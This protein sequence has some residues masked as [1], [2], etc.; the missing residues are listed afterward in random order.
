MAGAQRPRAAL[1][2]RMIFKGPVL[3]IFAKQPVAGR[4]KTRLC[5]PL[6]PE[7]ACDLYRV[8]LQE[9]MDRVA[10]TS[11]QPVLCYAG[12]ADWFADRFPG[13]PALAQ[14]TGDLGDRLAQASQALFAAGAGPVLLIGSDSPD[15]PPELVAQALTALRDV[16]LVTIPARD[17][18]YVLIGLQADCPDIFAEIPWSSPQVLAATRQR[19]LALRRSYR[20]VGHWEDLDDL[21][22]LQR[23]LQRSP[24]SPTAR[25]AAQHL[26]RGP[27]PAP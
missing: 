8:C 20:E 15:L 6:T 7:Q 22:S 27:A 1:T 17:G 3:C 19:A 24:A 5:P 14:S 12:Q 4:V 10:L 16:A 23:L 26:R 18:G 9:T 21:E 25:F 13:V 11:L 2:V